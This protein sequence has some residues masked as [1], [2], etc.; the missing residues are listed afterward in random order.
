MIDNHVVKYIPPE[1]FTPMKI[2]N[3]TW[4]EKQK[5]GCLLVGA[6]TVDS[7]NVTRDYAGLFNSVGM[8]PKKHL[9]RFLVTPNAALPTG[10]PLNVS[11]F[12]VGDH[13]DVRG[14]T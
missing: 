13:I 14:L 6:E 3:T 5:Y 7:S 12:R 10:T 4:K 8:L 9:F 11:H 2:R 1:K